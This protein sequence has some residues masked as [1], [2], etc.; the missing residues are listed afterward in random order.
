MK[1]QFHK[2]SRSLNPGQHIIWLHFIHI[3]HH[4][5]K[6]LK[7][8]VPIVGSSNVQLQSFISLYN[9]L[10]VPKLANNLISI[11]R[12]IQVWNCVVTFFHSH[13]TMGRTI[14]VTKEQ[15]L[16]LGFINV[17]D[18]HHLVY[19]RQCFYTYSQVSSTFESLGLCL[20][21]C[22]FSPNTIQEKYQRHEKPTLVPQPVQLFE[23]KVSIP[24]NPIEEVTNEMSKVSI[25]E[26]PI[27]NV[28][29]DMLIALRKGKQSCV[30]YHI[31]QLCLLTISLYNIREALKDENWIQAMK[32]EMKA[33]EKNST[34]EIVVIP[35]DKRVVDLGINYEE[36]FPPIANMNAVR[37]IP[38]LATH[39]GWNLKQFDVKNAFLHGDQE[40]EAYMK[41]P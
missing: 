33:L 35:K 10:H 15:I 6:Y 8:H 21:G 18:V 40:E 30:K 28:S 37:V 25:L 17:L 31:S 7:N 27:E 4:T 11:F 34:W 1:V 39:F 16:K 3:L 12:L 22:Y 14:G 20:N 24:K 26:N 2:A 23:L 36:T 5:L 41:I 32:E 38:S 9:V 29:D 19:L 13:L